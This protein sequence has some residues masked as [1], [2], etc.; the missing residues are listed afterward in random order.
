DEAKDLIGHVDKYVNGE[1]VETPT[2][3]HV[4]ETPINF[5]YQGYSERYFYSTVKYI[6]EAGYVFERK[7][8]G[9]QW[10]TVSAGKKVE[11]E[12]GTVWIAPKEEPNK[13]LMEFVLQQQSKTVILDDEDDFVV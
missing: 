1:R 6:S 9:A 2:T 12:D 10:D 13:A 11:F 4:L 3:I 5:I 7:E 8:D